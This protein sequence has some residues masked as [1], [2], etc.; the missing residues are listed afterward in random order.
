[1]DCNI[2]QK[3]FTDGLAKLINIPT[4]IGLVLI[5]ISSVL[6]LLN[7]KE[8]RPKGK[9]LRWL[10]YFISIVSF[11]ALLDSLFRYI[12]F[13]IPL[14]VAN[15]IGIFM[16]M[17]TFAFPTLILFVMLIKTEITA[18]L[19]YMMIVGFLIIYAFVIPFAFIQILEQDYYKGK[20]CLGVS[21]SVCNDTNIDF[22]AILNENNK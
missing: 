9:L 1:M 17:M 6:I 16:A 8:S 3:N 2:L 13:K 12:H 11:G 20:I 21:C 4:N 19:K 7:V 22:K 14:S 15:I 5:F 10:I 18:V